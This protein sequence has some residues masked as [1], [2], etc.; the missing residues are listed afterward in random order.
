MKKLL[1]ALIA[2]SLV[3]T[4]CSNSSHIL[5]LSLSPIP[6][7]MNLDKSI[8]SHLS[9]AVPTNDFAL[10]AKKD[11]A[12]SQVLLYYKPDKGDKVIFMAAYLFP[13]KSFDKL[14]NPNQPPSYGQ[15]VI[16]RNGEVLSIAG[17]SDSIFDPNSTDGKNITALYDTIYKAS[18][19]SPAP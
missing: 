7:S 2:S 4:G 10:S 9:V 19:Y 15:E 6:Y 14:K 12:I 18:T 1:L 8:A 17:P 3:L 5:N 13:Q 11:G 16:R